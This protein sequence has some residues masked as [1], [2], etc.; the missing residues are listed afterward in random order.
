VAS[1]IATKRWAFGVFG[2]IG[3]DL[4]IIR[5]VRI[6][7]QAEFFIAVKI[8]DIHASHSVVIVQSVCKL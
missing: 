5:I 7:E 8:I 4:H 6:F 1:A 2:W 3:F